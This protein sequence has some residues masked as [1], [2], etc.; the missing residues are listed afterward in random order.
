MPKSNKRTTQCLRLLKKIAVSRNTWTL[1]TMEPFSHYTQ[2]IQEVLCV[3]KIIYKERQHCVL[4]LE[5]GDKIDIHPGIIS[6]TLGM[7]YGYEDSEIWQLR[8]LTLAQI[9]DVSLKKDNEKPLGLESLKID[10]TPAKIEQIETQDRVLID[11]TQ[12][13]PLVNHLWERSMEICTDKDALT[14]RKTWRIAQAVA[15]ASEWL[16]KEPE[17]MTELLQASRKDLESLNWNHDQTT[18]VL[19]WATQERSEI[20]LGL[21]LDVLQ[22]P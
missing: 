4:I 11:V 22:S 6:G 9:R 1:N 15:H 18:V 3:Q 12:W 20:D 21:L 19:D 5:N 10:V 2:G 8:N 17:D 16:Q 13:V 14:L 7:W